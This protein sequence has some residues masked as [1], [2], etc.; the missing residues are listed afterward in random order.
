LVNT[1]I[2]SVSATSVYRSRLKSAKVKGNRR[3]EILRSS[4]NWFASWHPSQFDMG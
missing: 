2:I 4:A 3:I 1:S